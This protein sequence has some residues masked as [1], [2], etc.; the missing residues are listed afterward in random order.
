[1]NIYTNLKKRQKRAGE[2]RYSSLLLVFFCICV[3]ISIVFLSDRIRIFFCDERDVISLVSAEAELKANAD[4]T[5]AASVPVSE[6]EEKALGFVIKNN[7]IWTTDTRINLFRKLYENEQGAVTVKSAD[8]HRV[9]A[10]G[11]ENTYKFWLKNTGDTAVNYIM[12]IEAWASPKDVVIPLE[13][14]AKNYDGD[15]VIGEEDEWVDLAK[16]NGVTDKAKLGANQSSRY[17]LEWQ[18]PF[19]RGDDEADTHRG[20]QAADQKLSVHIV[21]KT[22]ATAVTDTESPSEQ[23]PDTDAD[24]TSDGGSKPKDGSLPTGDTENPIIYIVLAVVSLTLILLL[25]IF[26]VKERK[27]KV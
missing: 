4:S 26:G 15:W 17:T 7:T 20:N 10:P 25:L 27:E 11:T 14:R 19:E 9:I 5:F 8:K 2:R 24:P 23:E 1:M 6:S 3:M 21:I 16:L 18:W 22:M 12:K 13:V